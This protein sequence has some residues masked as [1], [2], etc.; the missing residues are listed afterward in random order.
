MR[1]YKS[2]EI[3]EQELEDFSGKCLKTLNPDFVISIIKE[4]QQRP[5]GCF[6]GL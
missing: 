6:N 3:K 2:I 5:V 4:A 1:S